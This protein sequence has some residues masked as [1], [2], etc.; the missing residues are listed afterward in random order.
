MPNPPGGMFYDQAASHHFPPVDLIVPEQ[1]PWR[2]ASALLALLL[3]GLAGTPVTLWV[4][5]KLMRSVLSVSG[6][7]AEL[8]D[9]SVR[10]ARE[11]TQ[12]VL[13][14]LQQE[15]VKLFLV[16]MGPPERGALPSAPPPPPPPPCLRSLHLRSLASP[17]H[18]RRLIYTP[19]FTECKWRLTRH[20]FVDLV[21]TISAYA[22]I[23]CTLDDSYV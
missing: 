14:K 5:T 22:V 12:D 1:S 10:A 17:G 20:R 18:R 15:G 6:C 21:L 3:Q 16:S 7:D 13:P 9:G 2:N 23:M 4:V 8:G 19:G 11:L